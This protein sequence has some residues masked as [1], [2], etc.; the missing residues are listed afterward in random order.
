ML[1]WADDAP[2]FRCGLPAEPGCADRFDF[3]GAPFDGFVIGMALAPFWGLRI[4]RQYG[5]SFRHAAAFAAAALM[6]PLAALGARSGNSPSA[7]LAYMIAHTKRFVVSAIPER[8]VSL[9]LDSGPLYLEQGQ[10]IFSKLPWMVIALPALAVCFIL[11]RNGLR[12]A[13]LAIM[14]F[15]AAYAAS[16]T[17]VPNG[18]FRYN[19]Y[20]YLRWLLVVAPMSFCRGRPVGAGIAH[21][22]ALGL[23]RS[24]ALLP[25]AFVVSKRPTRLCPSS[26]RD[27][28]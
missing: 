3:P 25:A 20:H 8:L 11:G 14:L 28:F 7:V 23:V 15:V 21:D 24:A 27:N 18:L 12:A 17:F 5:F 22:E 26:L 1:R 4:Y 16:T 6:G 2:P 10:T 13:V 19:N 9:F